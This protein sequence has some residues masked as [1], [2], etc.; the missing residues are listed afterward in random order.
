[1]IRNLILAAAVFAA[2]APALAQTPAAAPAPRFSVEKTTIGEIMA[3]ADAK[4]VFAKAM[5]ELV[6]NPRLEE[7]YSMTLPDIVQYVPEL[8]PEK[9][10]EIN[11][12]LA[13]IK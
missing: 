10:K 9:L 1:M 8:T 2:A 3:N 5:P 7:G 12:G 11:D 6:V 13:K 4:A